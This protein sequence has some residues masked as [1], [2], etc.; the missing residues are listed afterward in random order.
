MKGLLVSLVIGIPLLLFFYYTLTRFGGQWWLPFAII[1]FILSVVLARI[2]PV[3]ILP[4]FYKV[5]PLEDEE[6][7]ERIKLLAVG[8]GIKKMFTNLT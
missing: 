6:L 7:N 4:L 2:V 8:A 3:L 5:T 1:L